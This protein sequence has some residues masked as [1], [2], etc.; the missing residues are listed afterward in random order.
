MAAGPNDSG[1]QLHERVCEQPA[2]FVLLLPPGIRE[3]NVGFLDGPR[4]DQLGQSITAVTG[5]HS[6]VCQFTSLQLSVRVPSFLEDDL[7]AQV[8]DIRVRDR[9]V[10]QE[11]A[12]AAAD[13]EHDRVVVAKELGPIQVAVFE[14]VDELKVRVE[15]FVSGNARHWEYRCNL[16]IG[17]MRWC[18]Q[19]SSG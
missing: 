9:R 13:V 15:V 1:E 12:T 19:A 3:V 7:H 4:F 14:F 6:R 10:R 5:S 8:V 11:D 2:A 17:E 16:K 18:I